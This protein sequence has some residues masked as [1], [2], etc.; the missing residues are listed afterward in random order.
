MTLLSKSLL[1]LILPLFLIA[2]LLAVI[3]YRRKHSIAS[4]CEELIRISGK[5]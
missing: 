3:V 1:G 5:A 2:T 4:K